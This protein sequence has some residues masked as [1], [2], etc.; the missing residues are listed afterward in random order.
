[1]YNVFMK[2]ILYGL[3]FVLTVGVPTW[4]VTSCSS[5][6][7]DKVSIQNFDVK[8]NK[9]NKLIN[10]SVEQHLNSK[11]ITIISPEDSDLNSDNSLDP[12]FNNDSLN[13]LKKIISNLSKSI[14]QNDLNDVIL[15]FLSAIEYENKKLEIELPDRDDVNNIITVNS[16]TIDN[17]FLFTKKITTNITVK[18]KIERN[19][20][21]KIE[22]T[23]F[24]F[25]L[26]IEFAGTKELK[27]IVEKIEAKDSVVSGNESLEADMKDIRKIF[28]GKKRENDKNKWNSSF[29]ISSTKEYDYEKSSLQDQGIINY[30]VSFNNNVNQN[31]KMLGYTFSIFDF[32]NSLSNSIY[33]SKTNNSTVEAN[34]LVFWAPSTSLNKMFVPNIED[35]NGNKYNLKINIHKMKSSD[36]FKSFSDAFTTLKSI[37]NINELYKKLENVCDIKLPQEVIDNLISFEIDPNFVNNNDDDF[38]IKFKDSFGNKYNFE[39]NKSWWM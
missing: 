21:E 9:Q 31:A 5:S 1:M 2:K 35:N 18:Y 17:D 23:T 12:N 13:K 22:S 20:K 8:F 29:Y 10:N 27:N 32:W 15:D 26:Y 37:T 30:V 33:N 25:D 3:G 34:D 14:I 19:D 38:E 28:L 16:L 11:N 39:F 7:N 36:G 4:I 6:N 24:D